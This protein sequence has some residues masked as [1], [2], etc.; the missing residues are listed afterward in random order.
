[1]NIDVYRLGVKLYFNA[2]ILGFPEELIS[3]IVRRTDAH[4]R[5]FALYREEKRGAS[6]FLAA[7][8]PAFR[9]TSNQATNFVTKGSFRAAR[10]LALNE[11]G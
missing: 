5:F 6:Y 11:G 1:M 8:S 2:Q 10:P 7:G 3:W 4:P 9:R